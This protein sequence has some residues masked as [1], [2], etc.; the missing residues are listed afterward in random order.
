MPVAVESLTMA[1]S[2]GQA[3]VMFATPGTSGDDLCVQ[4]VALQAGAPAELSAVVCAT[5]PGST[6]TAYTF[7][8][9]SQSWSATNY[10]RGNVFYNTLG[11]ELSTFS[12]YLDAPI[13]CPVDFY[14]MSSTTPTGPWQVR[15]M[16]QESAPGGAGLIKS[17]LLNV[18]LV[19]GNY[20]GVGAGWDCF[21]TYYGGVPAAGDYGVGEWQNNIWDNAYPGLSMTYSPPSSG[22]AGLGYHHVYNMQ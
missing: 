13:G 2:Q 21:A 5:I 20:Y 1:D 10:F 14:V 15:A 6:G 17:G 4:A 12:V 19:P 16:T 7:A 9:T 22:T 18:T 3:Q 8:D 11:G